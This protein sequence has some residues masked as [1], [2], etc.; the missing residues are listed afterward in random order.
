MTPC[1]RKAGLAEEIIKA[2][3]QDETPT[4]EHADEALVYRF[5]RE[6][7]LDRGVADKT[8]AEAELLLGRGGVIDLVGVLGYYSLISMTIKAFDVNPEAPE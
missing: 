8:Y 6:L 5:A 2:L 7:N 1:A 3:A 4:F